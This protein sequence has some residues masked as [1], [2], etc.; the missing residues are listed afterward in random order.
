MLKTVSCCG[1]LVRCREMTSNDWYC[2]NWDWVGESRSLH[3]KAT[4]PPEP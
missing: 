3:R 2:G 1:R 4:P